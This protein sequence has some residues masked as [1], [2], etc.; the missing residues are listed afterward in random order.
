[1]LTTHPLPIPHAQVDCLKQ[2]SVLLE[3][4]AALTEGVVN[5]K[6]LKIRQAFPSKPGI[7]CPSPAAKDPNTQ[8]VGGPRRIGWPHFQEIF[9]LSALSQEDVKI[10]KVSRV[11]TSLRVPIG[12]ESE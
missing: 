9:M 3:L 1:M 2:K 7:N 12:S 11:K 5:G 8:S 10:L 4:T 6:K